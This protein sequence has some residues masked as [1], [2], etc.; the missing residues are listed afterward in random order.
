MIPLFVLFVIIVLEL[1]GYKGCYSFLFN[2]WVIETY[3]P[4]K[5]PMELKLS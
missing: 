5:A 4:D 3:C 1:S 2:L